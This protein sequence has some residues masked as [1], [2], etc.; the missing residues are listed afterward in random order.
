MEWTTIEQSRKKRKVSRIVSLNGMDDKDA[1]SKKQR[2]VSMIICMNGIGTVDDKGA[3]QK[4]A[5]DKQYY[6]QEWNG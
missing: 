5:Q 3:K 4:V 6:E 2:K 1:T